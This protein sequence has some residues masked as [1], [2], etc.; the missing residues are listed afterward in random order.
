MVSVVVPVPVRIS[1][2]TISAPGAVEAAPGL[3]HEEEP[4][5]SMPTLTMTIWAALAA[6]WIALIPLVG[7]EVALTGAGPAVGSIL[8]TA[9]L[10]AHHNRRAGL[11]HR[12]QE[13]PLHRRHQNRSERWAA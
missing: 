6:V 11:R 8:A 12:R 5:M 13:R 2:R 1:A 4:L 3:T 9:A 10:V 7:W